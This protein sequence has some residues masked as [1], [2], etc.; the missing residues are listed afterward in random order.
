MAAAMLSSGIAGDDGE[1]DERRGEAAYGSGL[2]T[3]LRAGLFSLGCRVAGAAQRKDCEEAE[4]YSR[5]GGRKEIAE[6]D[7]RRYLVGLQRVEI[8]AAKFVDPD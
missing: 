3:S 6:V 8:A 1:Q 4:E 2:R 7:E 5:A